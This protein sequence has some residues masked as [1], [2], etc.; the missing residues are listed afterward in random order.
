MTCR[1]SEV[2]IA[3][4]LVIIAPG[5]M[6]AYQSGEPRPEV[7]SLGT[8]LIENYQVENPRAALRGQVES[9]SWEHV[10]I[11]HGP[12]GESKDMV[13]SRSTKYDH[14]GHLHTPGRSQNIAARR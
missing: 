1:D 12:S 13:R 2:L 5:A 6:L 14:D 11:D 10:R 3:V 9:V 4:Y 8:L 7:F